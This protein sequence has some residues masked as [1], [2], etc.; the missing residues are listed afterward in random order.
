MS[1][2]IEDDGARRDADS[3]EW[4]CKDCA[5]RATQLHPVIRKMD[6]PDPDRLSEDCHQRLESRLHPVDIRC[7]E[8]G[9]DLA[10]FEE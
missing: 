6:N 4:L 5:I 10:I 3:D 9:E 8:C 1:V 2:Y 7:A